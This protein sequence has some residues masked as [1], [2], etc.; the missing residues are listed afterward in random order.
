[1]NLLMKQK[2]FSNM[3][4][5]LKLSEN[6]CEIKVFNTTRSKQRNIK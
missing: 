3:I 4:K 2:I 5:N 6:L 1:M